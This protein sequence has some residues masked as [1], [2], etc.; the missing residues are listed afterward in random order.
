MPTSVHHSLWISIRPLSYE[1]PPVN[2]DIKLVV[3]LLL[4]LWDDEVFEPTNWFSQSLLESLI[5]LGQPESVKYHG[6]RT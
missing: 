5:R 1:S 4:N 6:Y 3:N 2:E